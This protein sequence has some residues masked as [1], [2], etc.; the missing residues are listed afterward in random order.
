[1]DR[2]VVEF[3]ARCLWNLDVRRRDEKM[4]DIVVM[5]LRKHGGHDG[6]K[7]AMKITDAARRASASTGL[8]APAPEP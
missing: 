2:A 6:W 7:L 5:R 8:D 1:M 4:R 3:G